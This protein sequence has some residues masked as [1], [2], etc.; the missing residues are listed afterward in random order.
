MS[1]PAARCFIAASS[2]KSGATMSASRRSGSVLLGRAG[3]ER[4]ASGRRRSAAFRSSLWAATMQT[5]S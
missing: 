4:G 2:A 3:D 5:S 1:Q